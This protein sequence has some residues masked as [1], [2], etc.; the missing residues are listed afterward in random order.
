MRHIRRLLQRIPQNIQIGPHASGLLVTWEDHAANA[1]Q[2]YEGEPEYKVV[3]LAGY[4]G[5]DAELHSET[6][7]SA[8]PIMCGETELSSDTGD[9]RCARCGPETKRAE[10]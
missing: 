7:K 2:N 3:L 8:P 10:K 6:G 1:M 5:A 4:C 9:A